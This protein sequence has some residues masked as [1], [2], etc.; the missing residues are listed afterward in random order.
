LWVHDTLFHCN[1]ASGHGPVALREALAHSC[2]VYF[3]EIG[4]QLGIERIAQYARRLGLGA[5]TRIDLPHEVSGLVPSP[6]WKQ[7]TRGTAWFGGETV[8]VAIGQGQLTVTPLQAAQ[9]A[10]AVATGGHLPRPFVV[11]SEGGAALPH[12]TPRE[13][14]FRPETLVAIR[15]G[16]SASVNGGGTGALARLPG[17]EVCGK[18]GS[19]Q[20][21]SRARR[22]PDDRRELQPHAWFVGF[23]P[24]QDPQ[25]ALAVL[26]EH[27]RAGGESAAPVAR[28]ILRHFFNLPPAALQG[29]PG[30]QSAAVASRPSGDGT[31]S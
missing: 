17:I 10:A 6:A 7:R 8:S 25:I 30:R 18:T 21:V 24:A 14:G 13:L 15:E 3:Y 19:A 28:T 12:E 23:A 16:M 1:R 5:P 20:V 31:G 11:D 29:G 2:N 9:L 22:G 27:G 26:V 4:I